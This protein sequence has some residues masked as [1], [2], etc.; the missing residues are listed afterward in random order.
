M[1]VSVRGQ[2]SHPGNG[3]GNALHYTPPPLPA[4]R[5]LTSASARLRASPS[6]CAKSAA[7]V[8]LGRARTFASATAQCRGGTLASPCP[9]ECPLTWTPAPDVPLDMWRA[10]RAWEGGEEGAESLVY[11]C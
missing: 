9:M 3:K 11:S 2:E 1:S 6:G 7:G 4:L 8:L 5:G 10:V